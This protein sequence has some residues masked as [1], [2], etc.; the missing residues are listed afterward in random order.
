MATNKVNTLL[1]DLKTP[2]R[3]EVPLVEAFKNY[4]LI[5]KRIIFINNL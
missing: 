2:Q 5:T 4:V 3:H 1:G